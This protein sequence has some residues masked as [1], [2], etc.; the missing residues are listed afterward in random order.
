MRYMH[1]TVEKKQSIASSLACLQ[2]HN[3]GHAY[4]MPSDICFAFPGNEERSR[5]IQRKHKHIVNN[6]VIST[7]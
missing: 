4:F 6:T 7:T 1:S 3:R 2:I 5:L